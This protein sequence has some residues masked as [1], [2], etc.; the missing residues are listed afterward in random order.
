MPWHYLCNPF[1]TMITT[2]MTNEIKI[3]LIDDH[4]INSLFTGYMFTKLGVPFDVATNK[5]QALEYITTNTYTLVLLDIQMPNSEGYDVAKSLRQINAKVPII[6]FTSLPEEEVLPKALHSGM[7][8]Y[9]LKPKAMQEIW[10]IIT[11]FKESA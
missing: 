5:K 6:A 2:T 1:V 3:L 9:M 8:D 4:E 11:K 7:N 10:S